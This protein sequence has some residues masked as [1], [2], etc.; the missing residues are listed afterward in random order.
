MWIALAFVIQLFIGAAVMGESRGLDIFD[1]LA[2][3]DEWLKMNWF[4]VIFW[5]IILNIFLAPWSI[6][7]W[8]Y[9]LCTYGRD[10]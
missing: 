7:Y 3:Y 1:P 4:G 5:T 9:R 10:K 8:F 6:F 2:N